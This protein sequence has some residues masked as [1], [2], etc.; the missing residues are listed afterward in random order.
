MSEDFNAIENDLLVF[1]VDYK[2]V[3]RKI[4]IDDDNVCEDDPNEIIVLHL[5]VS[6]STPNITVHPATTKV[7]IDDTNEPDC[8]KSKYM[9]MYT[10]M[11]V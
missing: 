5:E 10:C 6:G 7:I 3:C 8:S 2:H 1:S 9:Y 4:T 11:Y